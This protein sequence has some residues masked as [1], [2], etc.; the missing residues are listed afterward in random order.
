MGSLPKCFSC[1]FIKSRTEGTNL[2]VQCFVIFLSFSQ[3]LWIW[4]HFLKNGFLLVLIA[5]VY[6]QQWLKNKLAYVHYA[7]AVIGI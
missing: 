6:L 4:E 3:L 1:T 5:V 2:F 7:K